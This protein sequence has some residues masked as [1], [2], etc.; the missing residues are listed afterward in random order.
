MWPGDGQHRNCQGK[1]WEF[2][3]TLRDHARIESVM[4]RGVSTALVAH[5][6]EQGAAQ[7]SDV[8]TLPPC[9]QIGITMERIRNPISS[10]DA[11][12]GYVWL[13]G[14]DG[15]AGERAVELLREVATQA[16]LSCTATTLPARSPSW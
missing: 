10:K 2:W 12:L 7:A 1:E 11:L 3:V 15:P 14:S 16:A 8:F 6:G 9:P 5:V 4:H 13:I